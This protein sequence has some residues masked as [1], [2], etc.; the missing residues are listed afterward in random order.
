VHS[1]A[2]QTSPNPDQYD[3]ENHL[4]NRGGG[5]VKYV[6]DGD[7]RRVKKLRGTETFIY[8]LDDR[9]PT[10]YAQ[11]LEEL[12]SPNGSTALSVNRVY[13]YGLDLISQK[14]SG[15]AT[16][17]YYGYDGHGNVRL[18]TDN[19]GSITDTYTY[20][21]FGI[22]LQ[23]TGTTANYYLYCGEE[24]DADL[25]M[26]NLR[27]RCMNPDS[28]RFWTMD[29]YEGNQEDPPSLHKYLYC[30]GNP[31]N[32]I[33]PSGHDLIELLGDFYVRVQMAALKAVTTYGASA[34]I[35]AS[36]TALSM[37]QSAQLLYYGYDPETGEPATKAAVAFAILDFVPA[38]S[39]IKRPLS[40]GVKRTYREGEKLIWD[41]LSTIKRIDA[42]IHHRI[43][44]EWAHLFPKL[45]PNRIANLQLI[46]KT[47]HNGV[48]GV[49]STWRRFK[50]SLGGR[51][52]TAE[53][54]EKT[55]KQIDATFAK[56]IKTIEHK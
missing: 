45:N 50:A 52:P 43:P 35:V 37:Y 30:H 14:I 25:G 22:L 12:Y 46:E 48:D 18:L 34:E 53:E 56:D 33:D 47:V 27:A 13:T 24:Y 17:N 23:Q 36:F 1:T 55:A 49:T 19:S 38:G 39:Q 7:G 8:V 40:E 4:I 10:G 5:Q 20:D 31:V 29:T 28:G 9:N 51:T 15:V 6:Y 16:P 42:D 3:F 11:V 41:S 54:V 2:I 44:L 32:A 21:A 26:Y